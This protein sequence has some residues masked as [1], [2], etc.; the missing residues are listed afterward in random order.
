MNIVTMVLTKV[1]CSSHYYTYMSVIN[2]ILIPLLHKT[3][4]INSYTN[5]STPHRT[6]PTTYNPR[7]PPFQTYLSIMRQMEILINPPAYQLYF[8][9]P[10]ITRQSLMTIL[11]STHVP[12][13]V[14][15]I[16]L[17]PLSLSAVLSP[18]LYNQAMPHN[19]EYSYNLSNPL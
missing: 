16:Y 8:V 6:K 3:P 15:L 19:M 14:L 12:T 11:N 10:F 2:Y 5:S 13:P 4:P 17:Q 18:T 7:S 9:Q 1:L